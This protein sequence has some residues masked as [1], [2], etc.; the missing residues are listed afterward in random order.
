MNTNR[1]SRTFSI[2][3]LNAAGYNTIG[4]RIRQCRIQKG[5]SMKELASALNR[6]YSFVSK[7]ECDKRTPKDDLLIEIGNILGVSP[8]YL[9]YGQYYDEID[10]YKGI[11]IHYYS[12]AKYDKNNQETNTSRQVKLIKKIDLFSQNLENGDIDCIKILDDIANNLLVHT[13]SHKKAVD[14]LMNKI[15]FDNKKKK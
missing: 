5:M 6:D 1:F 12:D 10:D 11:A 14:E 2:H 15:D 4:Q 9:K 8:L 7:Y 13:K 3:D